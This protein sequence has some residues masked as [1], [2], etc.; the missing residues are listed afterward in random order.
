MLTS[1]HNA[2]LSLIVTFHQCF[3]PASHQLQ[4]K[5]APLPLS[6]TWP[7]RQPLGLSQTGAASC[8]NNRFW[9]SYY[10]IVASWDANLLSR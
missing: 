10:H 5:S 3:A 9:G 8:E 6:L 4:A 1:E 2:D 7:E